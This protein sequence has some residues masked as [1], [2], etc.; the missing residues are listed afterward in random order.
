[1]DMDTRC[2]KA[3]AEERVKREG[4]I[5]ED[6]LLSVVADCLRKNEDPGYR[7]TSMFFDWNWYRLD[8]YKAER[9]QKMPTGVPLA[10]FM[11]RS[12]PPK[13]LAKAA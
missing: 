1:M 8:C 4:M 12:K 5:Y 7:A 6:A 10:D 13:Q 2:C 11:A 3:M 9:G